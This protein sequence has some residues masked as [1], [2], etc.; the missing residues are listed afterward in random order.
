[1]QPHADEEY[2]QVRST[3]AVVTC[4]DVLMQPGGA[5]LQ[6]DHPH[7]SAEPVVLMTVEPG[8]WLQL[9]L[10]PSP[11]LRSTLEAG[12][13][14]F[15]IGQGG[16][17]LMRSQPLRA[18][19]C[20]TVVGG[21][22]E[23]FCPYPEYFDIVQRRDTFRAE[24]RLGM[25]AIVTASHKD[26]SGSGKLKNLSMTGCLVELPLSA[27]TM[28]SAVQDGSPAQGKERVVAVELGFPDG[29]RFSID[30]YLR[31][32]VVNMDERYIRTGFEFVEPTQQQDR[33]LWHFVRE[34]E[35]E[36]ARFVGTDANSLVPSSLF[37]GGSLRGGSELDGAAIPRSDQKAELRAIS[38]VSTDR[39]AA[40]AATAMAR[41]L[42]PVAEFLDVQILAL[43]S[44]GN[45]EAT[46]LSRTAERVLSL[47]EEN[48]EELLFALVCERQELDL[49]SHSLAVAVRLLDLAEVAKLPRDV[50]K[51]IVASALV[52]DMG[53]AL[54]PPELLRAP[55]LDARQRREL[56]AHVA[57]LQPRLVECRWLAEKVVREV[58]QHVN[59]RLDG[60][61]YPA[62]LR[63][64]DLGGLARVAA[65]VDVIDAMG[66]HRADRKAMPIDQIYR[67]LNNE[68][69]RFDR[70]W[71]QR[72]R[73]RFGRYPVG[74]LLRFGTGQLGWV[75]RLDR[76]GLLLQA[77]LTEAAVP[78][79]AESLGKLVDGYDLQR[80]GE[81]V[82]VLMPA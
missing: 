11:H 13:E 27:A 53:K 41:R 76:D 44:G 4:L 19:E 46:Q 36:A 17:K 55:L 3:H 66:R 68:A 49:V 73:Q 75:R 62:A 35:R 58:T 65:V 81:V 12:T 56:Q 5:A 60:S 59:E 72:Y 33:E 48:R 50:S 39:S 71:L 40:D 82:E 42:A 9:D 21:R 7:A 37:Q 69:H 77:Q 38:S 16:G 10:T 54:L 52:H 29:T 24:L 47:R 14:F 51:A 78:P 2:Y 25:E 45:I 8:G 23:C 57:L 80:L 22:V 1:M 70:R 20:R 67:A 34:I 30:A 26:Q 43:R 31:H 6:L 79:S 15:L 74:T 64:R 61:G 18:S 28:L 63:D 32:Q